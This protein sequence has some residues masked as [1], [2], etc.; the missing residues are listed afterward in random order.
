MFGTLLHSILFIWPVKSFNGYATIWLITGWIA[1]LS[2][3]VSSWNTR[4]IAL[5]SEVE[6]RMTSVMPVG[7]RPLHLGPT[8]R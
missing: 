3:G 1:F 2:S 6:Q 5:P 7:F 4:G 8:R